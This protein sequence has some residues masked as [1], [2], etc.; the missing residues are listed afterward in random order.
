MYSGD[1]YIVSGDSAGELKVWSTNGDAMGSF[2][3]GQ[4]I[5]ALRS[6]Q[7]NLGGQPGNHLQL[8]LTLLSHHHSVDL[9]HTSLPYYSYLY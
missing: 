5:T 9:I 4:C 1:S 6:F 8:N 2:S 7:D 3:H